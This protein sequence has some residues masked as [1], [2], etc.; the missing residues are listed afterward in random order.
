M[1][2]FGLVNVPV[3]G[4]MAH[5]GEAKEI[6][7]SIHV[8]ATH[9]IWKKMVQPWT[10]VVEKE[11]NGKLVIKP[12]LGGVLHSARDGFK[13]VRGNVTDL[14]MCYPIWSPAG[15]HL[16]HVFGLPFAF[17]NASVAA[18]VAEELYPKYLKD[19]YEKKGIYL[20]FYS[21]M[22]TY[23]LISVKPVRNLEDLKGMKVRSPAGP[24]ADAAKRLGAVPVFMSIAEVY[25]ALQR[26]MIDA[27]LT[28][29]FAGYAY[30]FFEIAKNVTEL[31]LGLSA[32]AWGL[33]PKTFDALPMDL[34]KEL[35]G[36]LRLE[37]Q[38]WANAMDNQ[39]E[40]SRVRN[41]KEG[42][43]VITLGPDEMKKWSAAIEPLW[44][45]FIKKNEAEGLPAKKLVGEMKALTKQYSAWSVEQLR[46]EARK[47]PVQGIITF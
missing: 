10:E 25:T 33:N 19:E 22:A 24:M 35:Y 41:K 18:R 31:N 2:F 23:D 13:A 26:G 11:S 1:L 8:P 46:D 34:K 32:S 38:Y 15:F 5:A 40:A 30:R 14:A 4:P 17:P 9:L 42:I 29:N 16:N 6:R 28:P 39:N 44:Q 36:L 12:Y 27:V 7:L 47:N 45:D 3:L 37:S 20:A 43:N 21:A